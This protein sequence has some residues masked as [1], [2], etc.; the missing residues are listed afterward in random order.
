MLVKHARAEP[1]RPIF[2]M[3]I[4][5]SFGINEGVFKLK[6]GEIIFEK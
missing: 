3:M 1:A 2:I 6:L 5:K 4:A